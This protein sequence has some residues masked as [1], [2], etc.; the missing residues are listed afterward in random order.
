ML[1]QPTYVLMQQQR[2]EE[3]DCRRGPAVSP[4]RRDPAVSPYRR[5]PAVSPYRR[6]PAVRP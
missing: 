5:D 3:G 6:D 4:Y 1:W 2:R